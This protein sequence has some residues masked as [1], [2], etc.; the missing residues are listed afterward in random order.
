MAFVLEDGTGL[1]NSNALIDVA[2]ADTYF[3]DRGIVA[4][5]GD[6]ATVKQP[7]IVR[8]T[9]YICKRFKFLGD[10]YLE[11]QALEFP[12]VYD[13]ADDPQMPVK[14]QQAVAE[15]ALRALTGELAP[16]P[17][18][19]DT[20]GRVL[21]KFE[22]VGPLEERT[23]YSEGTAGTSVLKPYP[24]ADMLLRGLIDNARRVIR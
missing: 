15:Y 11:T 13:D 23:R 7:A 8:A 17:T 21:E 16:D 9:D 18:T 12:R 14:M 10:K 1:S 5:T 19:D 2:F 4:W 24:A 20:G 6:D 22:K 3:G